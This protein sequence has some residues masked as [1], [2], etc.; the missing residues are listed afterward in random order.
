MPRR[1][2]NSLLKPVQALD[3]L[4]PFCA[5]F[6]NCLHELGSICGNGAILPTSYTLSSD[7][8][9]VGH[10]SFAS[11]GYG[12]VYHGTLDGSS[13]SIKRMHARDDLNEATKV[14][15]R[16]CRLPRLLSLTKITGLLPRGCNLE[17]PGTPKHL[18][19]PRC[20]HHSPPTGFEL[21]AR[22]RPVG[23]HQKAP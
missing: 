2:S 17:T 19:T 22:R 6:R 20:H 13:V 5:A 1:P 9:N 12:D 11:R 8:L 21:D 23:I 3:G 4:D 14:C 7:L 16:R 10:D 18:A 15:Y